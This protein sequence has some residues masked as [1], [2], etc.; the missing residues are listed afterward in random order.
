MIDTRDNITGGALTETTFLV[1]LSMYMPNHGYGIMQF[2]ERE[3]GGRV[4]LGAGTLYGAINAL[5]KKH[6]IEPAGSDGAG[7]SKKEY[8]VTDLGRHIAEGEL[9]RIGQIRQIAIR[10]MGG[11]PN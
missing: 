9:R 10:I 8:A 4:S 11:E 1:L 7:S 5:L 6:W 2:I 3:T